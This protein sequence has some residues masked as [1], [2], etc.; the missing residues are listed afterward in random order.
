MKNNMN[1][2]LTIILNSEQE[3]AKKL[4]A[5]TNQSFFLTGRAG[6]GKTTFVKYI[7]ETLRH[8][9]FAIVAPTGLAAINAGGQTI[10]SFFGLPLDPIAPNTEFEA[11][12][13]NYAKQLVLK[14]VDTIII[15]EVS[16]VTCDI[17]D[18]IDT[19]LRNIM[20]N[21]MPFGGKQVLFVGDMYQLEPVLDMSD[22]G[23]VQF[24]NHHYN[25]DKPYFFNAHVF[26]YYQLPCVE[27]T[28]VYRQKDNNF[29]QVLEHI[30]LGQYVSEEIQMI[31][32]K[33]MT[34]MLMGNPVKNNETKDMT[35]TPFNKKAD[36]IN[37]RELANIH[38]NAFTYIGELEGDFN[39]KNLPAPA[40]LVLK[41]GA[42]VMF[43]RNDTDHR[44]VNGT[45][46]VVDSLSNDSVFVKI[47]ER[48]LEVRRET[49]TAVK[50][51][52]NEKTEKLE[53]QIVGSYT[54]YPL[55]LAWA[56][57]IHKSQGLTFERVVLDPKGIF[58]P[59]M[60]YVALSRVRSLDGLSLVN[61][62]NRSHIYEKKNIDRFMSLYSDLDIIKQDVALLQPAMDACAKYNYD[63]AASYLL[64][65]V[66]LAV[67]QKQIDKAWYYACRMLPILYNL[68]VFANHA[69]IDLLSGDDDRTLLLNTIIAICN[70]NYNVA[71]ALAKNG[72]SQSDNTEFY[73]LKCIA[74]YLNG[75]NAGTTRALLDWKKSLKS[76]NMVIDNRYY[77]LSAQANANLK[78]PYISAIQHIQR[79]IPRYLTPVLFLRRNMQ[80]EEIKIE[81][82]AKKDIRLV[83][84]FNQPI[85]DAEFIEAWDKGTLNEHAVFR[86][87]ILDYP[88]GE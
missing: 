80:A 4:I 30:R 76:H 44:W 31:N 24:Y 70:R 85:G 87:A 17:V 11:F 27:F 50:Y 23:V 52:F 26:R 56:I 20:T 68:D 16:M 25:T 18:A 74:M 49:W 36:D 64:E 58:S 34:N 48:V 46:G 65:H 59:G 45:I 84:L 7:Q 79:H 63:D 78:R 54:Q 35:L 57:T 62:V 32:A 41:E 19:I 33:G 72:I 1:E 38:S 60:L 10:H 55:R 81:T 2:E 3:L 61:Q 8:K 51:V 42:Q 15:D 28:T 82:N 86:K 43:C 67:N 29:L 37:E 9:R 13:L 75:Q 12:N 6:T 53:K 22:E 21:S 71:V 69:N 5:L 88:Y 83:N 66:L 77:Y 14:H 39:R 47:D 73:Y 40:Q